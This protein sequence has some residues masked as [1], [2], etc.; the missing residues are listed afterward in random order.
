MPRPKTRLVPT[1]IWHRDEEALYSMLCKGLVLHCCSGRSR[2]GHVRLDLYEPAD[3][4][5]DVRHLP[6]RHRSVDTV[7]CDPPFSLYNAYRW[8]LRLKDVVRK[9][10]VLV[11][12][13]LIFR[14]HGFRRRVWLVEKWPY[15][16]AK[17]VLVYDRK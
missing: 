14:L 8:A 5:A 17:L 1:W 13:M 4:R 10:L 2:L 3:I 6:I 7:I 9:R 11:T 15:V 12:P 16:M